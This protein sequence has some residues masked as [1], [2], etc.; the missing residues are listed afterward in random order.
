M[1]LLEGKMAKGDNSRHEKTEAALTVP[2]EQA[3]AAL[4]EGCTDEAA[5]ARAGVARQ[6]VNQW[7]HSDFGFIAELNRRRAA[8]WDAHADKLRGLIVKAIDIVAAA[9]ESEDEKTR[10]QAAMQLLKMADFGSL[11]PRGPTTPEAAATDLMLRSL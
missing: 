5:A 11:R 1:S 9:L 2:Q 7:R 10:T 6:T 8:L 3:L 4:L